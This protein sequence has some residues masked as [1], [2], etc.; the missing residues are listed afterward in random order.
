MKIKYIFAVILFSLAVFLLTPFLNLP[1]EKSKIN[2]SGKNFLVWVA[3]TEKERIRGLQNI[4]WLPKN[5]GMLFIFPQRDVHCF[6]NKNTFL[7]LKLAFMKEG[8]VVKTGYLL[9]IYKGRTTIC[10]EE[11]VDSVLEVPCE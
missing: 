3:R 10:S 7:K 4:F 5:R 11:S 6:W 1:R 2:I 8:K 9:P